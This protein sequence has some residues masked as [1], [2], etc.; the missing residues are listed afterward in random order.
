MPR[1]VQTT[2]VRMRPAVRPTDFDVRV[3]VVMEKLL[4]GQPVTVR[5]V[6]RG[7]EFLHPEVGLRLLERVAAVVGDA[8]IVASL[9]PVQDRHVDMV[10]LPRSG[11]P[12]SGSVREPRPME[13]SPSPSAVALEPPVGK[14]VTLFG[15]ALADRLGHVSRSTRIAVWPCPR[16][17]GIVWR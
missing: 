8:G 3:H 9:G 12:P 1:E 2:Y 5:V 7:R 16:R 14:L 11:R 13:P 10:L 15:S 6:F 4:D 17:Q